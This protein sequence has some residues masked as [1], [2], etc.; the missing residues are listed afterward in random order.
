MHTGKDS[1]MVNKRILN[2]VLSLGYL[3]VS[4]HI[5]VAAQNIEAINGSIIWSI[6]GATMK[7]SSNVADAAATA[8][9]ATTF[10]S[11]SALDN[12]VSGLQSQFMSTSTRIN[13]IDTRINGIDTR[14]DTADNGLQ[15]QV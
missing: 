11:Q 7:F 6:P 5:I 15:T 1:K 14:I 4:N 2:I 12:A 9:G 3:I 10:A 8:G 13:G